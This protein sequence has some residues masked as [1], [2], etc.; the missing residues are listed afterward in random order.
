M[1][2]HIV[3]L[4][5][6]APGE[7]RRRVQQDTTGHR[8]RKGDPLYPGPQS[9]ARLAH[10]GS[11]RANKNASVRP[12]WQMRRISVLKSPTAAP[13]KSETSSIKTH[14]PTADAWPPI[15]SRAYQRVPS[16]K[17]L[18]W[19]GPYAN[20]RT[21][22]TPTSTQPEQ[23][24]HRTEAINGHYRTRQMHRQKLPQP[25]Q[26]PT[27]NAPHRR[28]PRRLHPPSIM[29]SDESDSF[30]R[31]VAISRTVSGRWLSSSRASRP[32][33]AEMSVST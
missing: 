19:A 7:V 13:S 28:R 18:D 16:P 29:K 9:F 24:T 11:P 1:L 22:S 33:P 2:F 27:P 3:K 14:P 31:G 10:A 30:Y 6:D 25:H 23:A 20:G 26:L 5:G 8:G 21:H 4:D 12:S 32:R 15:S 17:S